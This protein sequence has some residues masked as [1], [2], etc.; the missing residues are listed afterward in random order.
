MPK[1]EPGHNTVRRVLRGVLY[2]I[3]IP[4][5]VLAVLL[6]SIA[7][8]NPGR[9]LFAA[10][11]ERFGSVPDVRITL[12]EIKGNVFS[13]ATLDSLK[14]S[15][16]KGVWLEIDG[17]SLLWTPSQLLHGKLVVPRLAAE[18]LAWLRILESTDEEP[19]TFEQF[20]KD[21]D[22]FFSSSL[23][24][25]LK[26]VAVRRLVLDKAL[27]VN[28]VE[29]EGTAKGSKTADSTVVTLNL[30]R[31]D[32]PECR[33]DAHLVYTPAGKTVDFS[34]VAFDHAKG[35]L[36]RLVNLDSLPDLTVSLEGKAP[37]NAW[38]GEF[39]ILSDTDTIFQ[40]DLSWNHMEQRL[41]YGAN[42]QADLATVV[43]AADA[44]Q[45]QK[46]FT[47]GVNG[48]YDSA[49][50]L[51]HM[52][53]QVDSNQMVTE[54]S[55]SYT[56]D[57]PLV[58]ADISGEIQESDVF[59]P[60]VPA[61]MR[62]EKIAFGGLADLSGAE[63]RANISAVI[64][65][66]AFSDVQADHLRLDFALS[67]ANASAS[68]E[69]T[70]S[71]K[72][73][74]HQPTHRA[75]PAGD[76]AP[77]PDAAL[78][79]RGVWS[80][81]ASLSIPEARLT[82]A[83]ID[84]AGNL[85]P[86]D[87][88]LDGALSIRRGD[89]SA[90]S[91]LIPQNISGN[92]SGGLTFSFA[93]STGLL[94][95]TPDL[96]VN[97]LKTP[98]SLLDRLM[99]DTT[100]LTGGIE[101][102]NGA[103]TYNDVVLAS[104]ALKITLAGNTSGQ[105]WA[106]ASDATIPDLSVVDAA[107]KGAG[108]AKLTVET[109]DSTP[110][111][112]LR[113]SI[114]DAS[115]QGRSIRNMEAQ[116]AVKDILNP[117][118]IAS[119]VNGV[120]DGSKL[121]GAMTFKPAADGNHSFEIDDLQ[122]RSIRVGGRG[123]LTPEN[124]L[125]GT[126]SIAAGDLSDAQPFLLSTITGKLGMALKFSAE[127]GK[128]QVS[129]SGTSDRF[130]GYGISAHRVEMKG[131]ARDVFGAVEVEGALHAGAVSSGSFSARNL[132]ADAAKRDDGSLIDISGDIEG[133]HAETRTLLS[134]PD[135]G[136]TVLDLQ[137]LAF[138]R[139]DQRLELKNKAAI[140]IDDNGVSI[141]PLTFASPVSPGGTLTLEAALGDEIQVKSKA[142]KL[143]LGII[144][145]FQ[146]DFPLDGLLTADASV[147]GPK[148][149]PVGRYSVEMSRVSLVDKQTGS[150][151]PPLAAK[152]T[153]S[154]TLKQTEL[155][156]SISGAS[157]RMKISGKVPFSGN[158]A[159]NISA[160]GTLAL[161]ELNGLLAGGQTLSGNSTVR[162]RAAGTI[163]KPVLEGSVEIQGATFADSIN[164]VQ[165]NGIKA[166]IK[167]SGD[168]LIISQMSATTRGGG[169]LSGNGNIR[170]SAAEGFPGTLVLNGTKARLVDNDT[171]QLIAD[172]ALKMEGRFA[173]GP[174]VSGT[175]TSRTANVTI[176][177]NLPLTFSVVR[178]THVNAPKY[179]E[180]RIA[181]E[182]AEQ[183]SAAA[184]KLPL[185]ITL[186]VK[187]RILVRG[188]GINADLD[189]SLK[190]RGTNNTPNI[191]GTFNLRRGFIV[192]FS[193]RL[194]FKSGTLGF[195]QGSIPV[196]DLRAENTADDVTLIVEVTGPASNPTFRFS[197]NPDLPQDEILSRLLFGKPSGSLTSGQAIQLAQAV[198]QLTGAGSFK[199]LDELSRSLGLDSISLESDDQGNLG[200]GVGK[201]ISKDVYMGFRQG[202]GQTPSKATVDVDI[203]DNVKV[204]G[205]VGEDGSAAV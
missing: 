122:Y 199:M 61:R 197:S 124:L 119:V 105:K 25:E 80:R 53:W 29:F 160:D 32:G 166:S 127:S 51:G 111:A 135:A 86:H 41:E 60:F 126:L 205:E 72:A 77:P 67:G 45:W 142:S 76:A 156:G 22:S 21:T 117:E 186:Q 98:Y 202:S 132:R 1:T 113:I 30:N 73:T 83:G 12:G 100:H 196:L 75:S 26:D 159:M 137:K 115:V 116:V 172:L 192:I 82:F 44:P 8:T 141:P 173:D 81:A 92:A 39:Y 90:L 66:P 15:D 93:P 194:D 183:R 84:I 174:A 87:D 133:I 182:T 191:L 168:K 78:T 195:E 7:S 88:T 176:P 167:G 147:S 177:D 46:P 13:S 31:N 184:F 121:T 144:R 50:S 157:S 131:V 189:G 181:E 200:V 99:A 62:W 70:F 23:D 140:T 178:V 107:L 95:A 47:A 109:P 170:L 201:R 120:I 63:P 27:V 163:G 149:A 101:Y 69:L 19:Y 103:C 155:S 185:D 108:A 4:L 40:G 18:R 2:L 125:D 180:E 179:I 16:D 129:L 150:T 188:R 10:A 17:L 104:P 55:L 136:H 20:L 153:G 148:S 102:Q 36:S 24:I 162:L 65:K 85:A 57:H 79:L 42:F 35:I 68:D 146:P 43:D 171:F 139:L 175:I 64:R 187:N 48:F 169:A 94:R 128:Q 49:G 5:I 11:I 56:K 118:S 204:Q 145:L 74:L 33:V 165:L 3:G 97:N 130:S 9:R 6:W 154:V 112:T 58:R 96:T 38:R 151:L 138:S 91:L 161:A 54:G 203:T 52:K 28:A 134:R 114:P 110:A 123:I 89:L 193:K 106:L 143:S 34:A 152:L 14:L 164:G 71:G 59:S 158:E 190:V 198:A 37:L